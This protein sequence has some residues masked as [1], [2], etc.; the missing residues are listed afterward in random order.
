MKAKRIAILGFSETKA[1]IIRDA[2]EGTVSS[3]VP[4][5]FLQQH[6]N[7][8]FYMDLAAAER[9]TRHVAPWTIK[10]VNSD[11]DMIYDDYWS[12]KAVIWLSQKINKPIL[13]LVETDYEDN[14]LLELLN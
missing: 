5:T 10:G 9:L 6:P 1:P 7:V 11:P 3:E 4:A 13:S 12:K 2:I 8:T 14:G